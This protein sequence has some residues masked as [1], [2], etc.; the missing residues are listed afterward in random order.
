MQIPEQ[1]L[2]K[3]TSH[4]LAKAA[5][6]RLYPGIHVH[7]G[8]K[9]PPL[10]MTAEG[11][12]AACYGNRTYGLYR[13]SLAV[14]KAESA[15]G[16]NF[17]ASRL[18]RLLCSALHWYFSCYLEQGQ[19]AWFHLPRLMEKDVAITGIQVELRMVKR[20]GCLA[21]VASKSVVQRPAAALPACAE[22]LR[23]LSF[24]SK[25]SQNVI[26]NK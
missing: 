6:L 1:E 26:E 17:S 13:C 9:T 21:R 18:A 19:V 10:R 23:S 14:A 12:S 4:R 25:Q 5:S 3:R 2:F 7:F 22:R 16:Q 11:F 8:C 20:D 15:G 24:F